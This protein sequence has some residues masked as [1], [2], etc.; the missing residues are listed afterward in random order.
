[1]ITGPVKTNHAKAELIVIIIVLININRMK[2]CPRERA[3]QQVPATLLFSPQN[4]AKM[5]QED[6]PKV[7]SKVSP[8]NRMQRWIKEE[9][10]QND[11]ERS[12]D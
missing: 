9:G 2:T 4:N 6:L 1:M 5:D 8:I 12:Y 11:L 3:A 7:S 10:N